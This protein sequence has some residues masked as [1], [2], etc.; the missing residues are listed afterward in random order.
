MRLG[1]AYQRHDV[2]R[3]A[4]LRLAKGGSYKR[5]ELFQS[6]GDD[7]RVWQNRMLSILLEE[8]FIT[9]EGS[10]N[11]PSW[12]GA[13]ATRLDELAHNPEELAGL[14]KRA[15]TVYPSDGGY[16]VT[17][18][19]AGEDNVGEDDSSIAALDVEEDID[20]ETALLTAVLR[21]AEGVVDVKMQLEEMR[22]ELRALS[23]V[24]TTDQTLLEQQQSP[25]A[26]GG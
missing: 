18:H 20:V 5:A 24:L 10:R 15:M 6:L 2:L 1:R 21:I 25:Q 4:L 3:D 23:T 8:G 14:M 9:R 19:D 13:A 16:A 26:N 11:R 22:R 17:V 7:Q 12:V